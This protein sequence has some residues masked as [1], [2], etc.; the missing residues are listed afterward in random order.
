MLCTWVLL[1]LQMLLVN[2]TYL[3]HTYFHINC[4][5]FQACL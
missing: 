4:I 2:L 3:L 1:L 5:I